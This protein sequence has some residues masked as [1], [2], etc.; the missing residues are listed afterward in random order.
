MSHPNLIALSVSKQT[1]AGKHGVFITTSKDEYVI[2][3]SYKTLHTLLI[4]ATSEERLFAH[5]MGYL[6]NLK[7][8]A[9][10]GATDQSFAFTL[11]IQTVQTED[12]L[13]EYIKGE[14]GFFKIV[15]VNHKSI[16]QLSN[17]QFSEVCKIVLKL[18]KN[19]I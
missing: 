7:T 1:N 10:Q 6:N 5:V 14:R 11:P 16:D 2:G 9:I 3:D 18:E 13:V 8:S 19:R 4:S 17:Y 15:N 12:Y